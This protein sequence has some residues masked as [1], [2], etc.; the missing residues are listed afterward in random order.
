MHSPSRACHTEQPATSLCREQYYGQIAGLS[1]NI[2]RASHLE[3]VLL[4]VIDCLEALYLG[5]RSLPESSIG[6]RGGGQT[7]RI[8]PDPLGEILQIS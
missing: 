3:V 4:Y 5:A 1:R 2:C 7:A 6:L 8:L